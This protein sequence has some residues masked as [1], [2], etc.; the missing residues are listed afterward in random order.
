M[1][2]EAY[3]GSAAEDEDNVSAALR[4]TTK[5]NSPRPRPVRNRLR[6]LRKLTEFHRSPSD[7]LDTKHPQLATQVEE[8]FLGEAF[9]L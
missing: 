1:T 7:R 9:Q 4:P 5:N 6:N 8:T 2:H 3:D